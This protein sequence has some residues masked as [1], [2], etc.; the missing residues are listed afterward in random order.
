LSIAQY[1]ATQSPKKGSIPA[2]ARSSERAAFIHRSAQQSPVSPAR[3]L[4]CTGKKGTM[5][6]EQNP[7]QTAQIVKT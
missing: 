6:Y 7:Q 4:N 3:S 5:P 1:V 2:A